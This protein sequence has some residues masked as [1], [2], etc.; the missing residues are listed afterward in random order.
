[1][2]RI[3][4]VLISNTYWVDDTRPC[5]TYGMRG[6]IKLD[7]VVQGPARNLHSG[8]D[9][10]VVFEPLADLSAVLASLHAPSGRI[11]VPGFYDDMV[12]ATPTERTFYDEVALDVDSYRARVGVDALTATSPSDILLAR[13]HRPTLTIAS[14]TTSNATA[15]YSIIPRAAHAKSSRTK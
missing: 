5:L 2:P 6:V 8:V 7:V 10:G 13:W 3:D 12:A 11:A 1:M 4:L 9:G 14:I 15:S